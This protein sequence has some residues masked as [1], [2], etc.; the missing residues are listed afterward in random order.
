[1]SFAR[2]GTYANGFFIDRDTW[3]A[4]LT[5]IYNAWNGISTDK[6]IHHKFS[7]ANPSLIVDQI[8]AGLIADFRFSGASICPISNAGKITNPNVLVQKSEWHFIMTADPF[9]GSNPVISADLNKLFIFPSGVSMRITKL[10]LSFRDVVRI[11]GGG[12]I[13]DD[14]ILF[15]LMAPNGTAIGNG[16][17]IGGS[18]L[19]T[20]TEYSENLNISI[21]ANTIA[22]LTNPTLV[23]NALSS[24]TITVLM[25][26]EQRLG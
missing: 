18:N 25:E 17:R 7:G 1:M 20:D 12:V 21:A 16:V 3:V 13:S 26:W 11:G 15:Q 2:I 23:N 22:R 9:D 19:N 5:N 10:S 8:G 14:N 24:I 6:D 4:E